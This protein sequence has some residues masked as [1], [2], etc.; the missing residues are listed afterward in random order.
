MPGSHGDNYGELNIHYS[1]YAPVEL[2]PL[3]YMERMRDRLRP[4]ST[5]VRELAISLRKSVSRRKAVHRRRGSCR[6]LVSDRITAS[7]SPRPRV[8]ERNLDHSPFLSL[9]LEIRRQIYELY[10][11]SDVVKIQDLNYDGTY[12]LTASVPLSKRAPPGRGQTSY[13]WKHLLAL[14]L[15]CRT[16]YPEAMEHLYAKTSFHFTDPRLAMRIPETIAM[17]HL[18]SIS[19]IGFSFFLHLFVDYFKRSGVRAVKSKLGNLEQRRARSRKETTWPMLWSAISSLSSLKH[20]SLQIY[21][22]P[23]IPTLQMQPWMSQ[24]I[25]NPFLR[26]DKSTGIE[27]T[28][29]VCWDPGPPIVEIFKERGYQVVLNGDGVI[30]LTNRQRMRCWLRV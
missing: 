13:L 11:E 17:K 21:H 14:P 7:A 2:A 8:T 12:F 27:V 6:R 5:A 10:Y 3:S 24:Y 23:S 29:N 30:P 19:A 15:T 22:Y 4:T 26:F 1:R 16:I 28:V 20:I 25:L 9:P 18:Q